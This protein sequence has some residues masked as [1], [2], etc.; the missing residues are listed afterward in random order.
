MVVATLGE[1][2]GA[3]DLIVDDPY[4]ELDSLAQDVIVMRRRA[5]DLSARMKRMIDEV[6]ENES[7]I[8]RLIEG[9][10]LS[11]EEKQIARLIFGEHGPEQARWIYSAGC[12][13][14]N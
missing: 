14:R 7:R 8:A 2:T 3:G 1:Q 10:K 12:A 9:L 11:S 5:R 6:T 4:A 13:R